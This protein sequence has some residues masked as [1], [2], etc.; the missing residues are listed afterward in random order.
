[1]P[2]DN[3]DTNEESGSGMKVLAGFLAVALGA[4]GF[5]FYKSKE[6]TAQ[7]TDADA[8][9]IATLS[10]QVSEV[11][12][13]LAMET[14]MNGIS[15]SNIQYTL[16]RRASELLFTSNR[17]VQTALLLSNAQHETHIAQAQ[18][19]A[20]ATTI[21][22]L[23]AHR[24]QL[25][26]DLEVIPGLQREIADLKRKSQ[27]AQFAQAS[28]QETLSRLRT[29]NA[30]LERQ[31]GDPAFLRLQASRAEDAAQ[32][33]QR[34]TSKQAVRATDTRVRL[35]LQPDGSV[36]PAPTGGTTSSK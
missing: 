34:T 30:N 3:S 17:L 9:T 13:R 28:L 36:R 25:L 4:T 7:Q 33:R 32:V 6:A 12:T 22:R 31:L 35:E 19:P 5:F 20:S 16:S 26:R 2:R 14:G 15:Q 24:D 23:E 1:M 18:L 10:N 11:R 8:K 27:D 21:A 29:E